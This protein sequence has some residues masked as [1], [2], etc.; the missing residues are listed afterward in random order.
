MANNKGYI[1]NKEKKRQQEL[2]E[3]K[4]EHIY[5]NPSKKLWGKIA[6]IILVFAM[7]ALPLVYLIYYLIS[8][9]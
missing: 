3:Q 4:R 8:N 5:G 9:R 7:V 2:Q 1:S 6:I